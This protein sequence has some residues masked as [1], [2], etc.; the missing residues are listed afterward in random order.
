MESLKTR[1][2]ACELVSAAL[3]QRIWL[4]A[5]LAYVW[6]FSAKGI[7][8]DSTARPPRSAFPRDH[9]YLSDPLVE[10]TG[11]TGRGSPV[12]LLLEADLQ[13]PG[14]VSDRKEATAGSANEKA[15]EFD[16]GRRFPSLPGAGGRGTAGSPSS[17]EERE[18]GFTSR[19]LERPL[20][21]KQSAASIMPSPVDMGALPKN[22]FSPEPI[23][24]PA[25]KTSS[26]Q[27]GLAS[28]E[29]LEMHP[30]RPLSAESS[31]LYRSVPMTGKAPSSK[32]SQLIT[33]FEGVGR[34]SHE[35]KSPFW[36]AK[37][38]L[39]RM[40]S[41]LWKKLREMLAALRQRIQKKR[42]SRKLLL[43]MPVS[44]RKAAA[45]FARKLRE[46]RQALHHQSLEALLDTRFP[47]RSNIL[48]TSDISKKRVTL[49]RLAVIGR[50]ARAI[51]FE[52]TRV[53]TGDQ[54]TLKA[55]EDPR[56]PIPAPGTESAL[57][58]LGKESSAILLL[59]YKVPALAYS[60]L[61][62]M[63]AADILSC[64]DDRVSVRHHGPPPQEIFLQT[65]L[66]YPMAAG[67]LSDVVDS[68]FH[69]ERSRNTE[70][71]TE[72]RAR[73][74]SARL[75]FSIQAVRLTALLHFHGLVHGDL[76]AGNFFVCADGTLFL[77][78]GRHLTTEGAPYRASN[79]DSEGAPENSRPT[80]N[81]TFTASLNSW[82]VGCVLYRIW[83]EGFPFGPSAGKKQPWTELPFLLDLKSGKKRRLWKWRRTTKAR[84]PL[85]FA[86]CVRDMPA[87]VKNL[88][89]RL[90]AETPR[91]RL[92][93]TRAVRDPVFTKLEQEL[94]ALD[95]FA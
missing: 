54:W 51:A 69:E 55:F 62:M 60:L 4:F 8:V 30:L 43:Q 28:K 74:L 17:G 73:A 19:P 52:V 93:P 41:R 87:G 76:Q 88:I 61:R 71:S 39:R 95:R 3:G 78:G 86:S 13:K 16:G 38:F 58:L 75:S 91:Q 18:S 56:G 57:E 35:K 11:G 67:S 92:L 1:C 77:G 59:P 84:K 23:N 20:N 25:P 29:Y 45:D 22:P 64:R 15:A 21:T 53:E 48:C 83:C 33:R 32:P 37:E 36:S 27:D 80:G 85:S 94:K 10:R 47:R 72:E 68:M 90:L 44:G 40:A 5:L 9:R 24:T 79:T 82:H 89:V 42:E 63:V 50:G 14:N 12:F 66:L 7:E 2:C 6:E 34:F 81:A 70:P 26:N 65:F 49:Q 46:S 31:G